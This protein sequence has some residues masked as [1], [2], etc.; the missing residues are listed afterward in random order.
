MCDA[1]TSVKMCLCAHLFVFPMIIFSHYVQRYFHQIRQWWQS[2]SKAQISDGFRYFKLS[3]VTST[4][5]THRFA[6]VKHNFTV[7]HL[8]LNGRKAI[9][10]VFLFV[11]LRTKKNAIYFK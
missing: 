10:L 7:D 6:V 11:E 3:E 2:Q 9:K 1:L 8:Y 4:E 5:H